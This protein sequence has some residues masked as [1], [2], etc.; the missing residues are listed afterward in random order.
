MGLVKKAKEL[1][2]S[3]TQKDFEFQTYKKGGNGGQ[4]VQKTECCVRCIH[5]PSG[6][7]GNACEHREQRKN[8]EMAFKRMAESPKFQGWLKMETARRIAAKAG[9]YVDDYMAPHNFKVEVKKDGQWVD[10]VV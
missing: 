9:N 1:V 4:K 6:A 5:N 3:L 8:K 10:E 2:F 7:V